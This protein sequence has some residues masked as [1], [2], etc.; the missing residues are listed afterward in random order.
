MLHANQVFSV[1]ITVSHAAV[2]K[3]VPLQAPS[4]RVPAYLQTLQVVVSIHI[5]M[6]PA[7]CLDT[8][9]RNC[10]NRCRAR[11]VSAMYTEAAF[12]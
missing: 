1:P 8:D 6:M 4:A 10:S 7:I 5:R 12:I 9:L 3:V 11:L 2:I